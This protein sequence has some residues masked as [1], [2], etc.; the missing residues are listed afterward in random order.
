MNVLLIN[1]PRFNELVGNNPAIIETHRGYNPPLG[2]LSL[3]GY[4]EDNSSHEVEILDAQP[5]ELTYAELAEVLLRKSPDVVGITAMTFTLTDV[6]RTVRL[7][8]ELHPNAKLVLGG[9]HV[10]IYPNETIDLPGVDFLV[11]GEGEIAFLKLLEHLHDPEVQEQIGGM[12]FKRG[13]KIINTGI[14]PASENLDELGF[15]ARHLID[16]N[17]YTSLLGK[18]DVITTMFTSRGCPYRCTFCDRP[19]SPV[20]SGFR[21]RTAKH[22]ADEIEQCVEMGIHEAFI[23]DDTFTVRKDRV[24]ELCEEIKIRK[25]KFRWDVRAHVNT[26]T[27]EM[28]RAMKDAGCDRIHYGVESG[29][30][31]MLKVIKKNSTVARIKDAVKWTKEADMEVLT[32]FI[33]GQQTETREDIEDSVRLAKELDPNYVHFTV[34]CPYPATEIYMEGL[35]RGIIKEDVWRNF[36]RNPEAK[37]ELPFWEENFTRHELRELLVNCYKEFYLRPGYILKNVARI[38]SMGEFKRKVRAGLSVVGMKPGDKMQSEDMIKRVRK[39][40][41]HASYEV[42]S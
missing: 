32:Y 18:D 4:L 27:P 12:V 34:F 26:M 20:I 2:I 41:P 6:M 10:H 5:L 15:P 8:K 1:P 31:R 13:N 7:V 28:L 35:S 33:I 40:V 19:F 37:Y 36:A 30:D 14:A 23:Y 9:P 29:N 24:F 17:Q 3:A 16:V 38:R 25:L 39:V 21:S 22:V 11:Q 42:Y